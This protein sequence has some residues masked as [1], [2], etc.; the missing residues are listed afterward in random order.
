[1]TATTTSPREIGRGSATTLPNRWR[2]HPVEVERAMP[3]VII[4]VHGVNDLGA[5]YDA[6]DNGLCVGLNERL[7]RDD[8]FPND[9][10]LP[11]PGEQVVPDPDKVYFRLRNNERTRSPVIPFYWGYRASKKEIGKKLING[12]V[13]DRHGNRLDR[14]FAKGGGMFV[15]ATSNIPDMFKGCF[16]ANLFT[17]IADRSADI[18]HPLLQAPER[19]YMAL[20]I[21]R[22]VALVE[23]IRQVDPDETVTLIGHSQGCLISLAAQAWLTRPADCLILQHPPYGLHEPLVDQF[24]QSGSEQ[25][26]TRARVETLV[27]LVQKVCAEP[28]PSPVLAEWND[29]GCSNRG[30]AGPSWRPDQG[31]RPLEPDN[32][33]GPLAVFAERDNRGKV[34]LYFC[35]HDLTVGLFNVGGI[36]A[37]G[38]PDTMKY[39][40][41]LGHVR[42][43][44][45]LERLGP[46]F[47]QRVWSWRERDGAASMVGNTPPHDYVMR[48]KGEPA[49][50]ADASTNWSRMEPEIG[51]RRSITGE[52]LNPPHKPNLHTGELGTGLQQDPRY[53]GR[54]GFDPIEAAISITNGKFKLRTPDYERPDLVN[55]ELLPTPQEIEAEFNSGK[56]DGG[57]TRVHKV[58]RRTNGM[59]YVTRDETPDEARQRLQDDD[60]VGIPNSYHSAIV[61]NQ[62][63]HRWVTAMDVALG[64]GRSLDDPAWRKLLIA[65]A[66]WRTDIPKT[67]TSMSRYADLKNPV[68]TLLAATWHYYKSGELPIDLAEQ[69]PPH[70]IVSETLAE[71]ANSHRLSYSP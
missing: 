42:E 35:P 45:I 11:V 66:D 59:V 57:R 12:E 33:D 26:T 20:A 28:H 16:N 46:R 54:I 40:D 34:Y 65:M 62:E 22:L 7:A 37:L 48:L 10:T 8:L 6:L 68:Q 5:N 71:R 69:T 70:P 14:D 41:A 67:V 13:V 25:Q 47:F 24:T 29:Y 19:R 3:G 43:H 17:W 36:G 18:A 23:T 44:P 21:Q 63:H 32:S 56:T 50:D 31:C 49:Y 38:V 52:A 60:K 1:M 53:V 2:D 58:E 55:R 39:A 4:I 61:S 27:N 30:H 15:N 51:E 9:Y 64:Q